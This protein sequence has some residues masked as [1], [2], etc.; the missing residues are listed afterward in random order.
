MRV[1]LVEAGGSD[2]RFMIK[3]P[4]GFLRAVFNPAADMLVGYMSEP[5]PT[6]DGR[7]LWLPR[8]KVLGG[9]LDQ[10]HVLHARPR[11]TSTPG[12]SWAAR[13]GATRTC[14][15]TS[16]DGEQLARRGRWHGSR[17][18]PVRPIGTERLL[19]DPLMQS[20]GGSGFCASRGL[21]GDMRRVSPG[22]R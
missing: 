8:G 12:G 15:P 4:L 17:A 10:R 7:R 22:A 6:L 14:C 11:G 1:L 13:A 20:R 21:H 19:H 5:E 16:G 18:V 3:M 2:D 9:P